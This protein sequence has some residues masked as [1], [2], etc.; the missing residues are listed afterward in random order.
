MTRWLPE[1]KDRRVPTTT[2]VFLLYH[3]GLCVAP[4]RGGP[5][6][7]NDEAISFVAVQQMLL[8]SRALMEKEPESASHRQ[9]GLSDY[10][11]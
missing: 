2:D 4:C 3:L 7:R 1:R 11:T 6:V 8:A 9:A 10:R 5:W